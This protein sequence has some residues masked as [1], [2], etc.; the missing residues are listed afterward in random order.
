M[1]SVQ[2]K[3]LISIMVF[4]L[5][6]GQACQESESQDTSAQTKKAKDIDHQTQSNSKENSNIYATNNPY[7]STGVDPL[8]ALYGGKVGKQQVVSVNDL[9]SRFDALSD[10][11]LDSPFPRSWKKK[12]YL[13]RK[14]IKTKVNKWSSTVRTRMERGQRDKVVQMTLSFF[15]EKNQLEQSIVQTL[16]QIKEFKKIPRDLNQLDQKHIKQGDESLSLS[17]DVDSAKSSSS[18][19]SYLAT[20]EVTWRLERS[21]PS[22]ELKNCRYVHA[23][24]PGLA[25]ATVPWAKQHF[26]ST[27]TRRFVEWFVSQVGQERAWTATWLYRNGSYRDKGVA[28]WTKKLIAKKAKQKSINGMEQV[29]S[30]S[31]QKEIDWWP[32][33]DPSPMGCEIAGPLLSVRLSKASS[34]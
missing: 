28:W 27:S 4:S 34:N 1:L 12:I 25:E 6:F 23:L 8:A 24:D 33:S 22:G 16:S 20:L 3:S 30:L 19:E 14:T 31:K 29:W 18:Q 17:F 11:P 9:K 15:G 5:T 21:N 7:K 13:L 2:Y 10:S 32:E 26:K